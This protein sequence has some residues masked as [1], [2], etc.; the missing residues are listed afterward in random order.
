MSQW[1][2]RTGQ[3][4]ERL[5]A[6]VA[7]EPDG[8]EGVCGA[9]VPEL[10]GLVPLVG[11]DRERIESLRDHAAITRKASGYPVRMVEFST[12]TNMEELP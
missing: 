1:K 2:P 9:Y 3:K 4:I 7:T 11:A 10:G 5:Y 8:G 6:W 12:R